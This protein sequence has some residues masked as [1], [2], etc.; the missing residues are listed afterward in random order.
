MVSF[1]RSGCTT[2]DGDSAGPILTSLSQNSDFYPR[3]DCRGLPLNDIVKRWRVKL[4]WP[5]ADRR[6]ME[7]RPLRLFQAISISALDL[8]N[9]LPVLLAEP[10]VKFVTNK[11]G[12]MSPHFARMASAL[13]TV[14]LPSVAWADRS[15][16]ATLAPD[17]FLNL[18]TGT[19]SH[20][21][22]DVFWDGKA[23]TA[24]GTAGL[25]NLGKFGSRVFKSIHAGKAASVTYS[26][27]PIPASTLVAGD[28]F[29]VRTNGGHY[30][31]VIV[32]ATDWGSLT[33]QYTTFMAAKPLAASGPVIT[34]VQN[35][36]S[37]ILPGLPNG[38]IAPGSLFVIIGTGLSTAAAPVLQSS[39]P[40]GLLTTLNQTSVA[41]TV[42]GVTKTPALYYTSATQLAAVLPST[43]PVGN[44]TI[45]VTYNGQMSAAAPIQVVANA[46]GLDTFYGTGNGAGAVT[47]VDGNLFRL[48]SSAMPGQTIVLWGSG[49]GADPSNDDR[50]YPQTQNNLTNIPTQIFIGGV[51]ATVVYAGRSQYPGL[52]QYDVVIPTTVTPGCFVSAVVQIGAA[53]ANAIVSNAVTM[54]VM[55]NGGPCSDPASGLSGT[56]IQSL[57]NKAG[58]SAKSLLAAVTQNN[59]SNGSSSAVVL[60][61]GL[62][63]TFYGNGYEYAS[64]GS[65]TVVPPEQ[66]AVYS[67][68]SLL[69]TD[70]LDAGTIQVS[71]PAG[72]FS[73]GTGPGFYQAQL[74]SNAVTGSPGTYTFAGSGG[75][76]VGN[77][78][79]AIST[80]G[81]LSL[82]N[83]PALAVITRAQ[84]AT[85]TW[86]GGFP[87]GDVQV[88]GDVGDQY[89][90]VR[91]YCHAPSSAGQLAIPSSILLAMPPG[92]GN[93]VVTNATAAQAISA[94]GADAGLATGIVMLKL[95]T[96]F[97]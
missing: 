68:N 65:C 19:A 28:V 56:Q 81:A 62:P 13:L 59:E 9:M 63:S 94:T 15:G 82:T 44:G 78:S 93:L 96:V 50:T 37:Y 76:D 52:D 8:P 18:E 89:G 45:T 73:L 80:N 11:R 23:L 33:L 29:G 3:H 40:P 66:G 97:K 20:A 17:T 41:V 58:G 27:A 48:T 7:R 92:G 38:G 64:Q 14:A 32:S 90:T 5:R 2:S 36:Y 35:N 16:T 39:A 74:P 88:E 24:Q 85:V 72:K 87:N 54:P 61:A 70:P 86:S 1:T 47:D 46:P 91:F 53:A 77:F 84:G 34:E 12:K 79:V 67:F 51:S 57:A 10:E 6:G 69:Q 42:N 25:F 30:A 75:K 49:I 26:A 83:Q 22:G 71:G 95:N 21:G 31:K 60:A 55:P 4:E 43:T